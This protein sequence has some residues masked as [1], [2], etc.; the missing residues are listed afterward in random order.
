M[1]L[2]L[3]SKGVKACNFFCF[4]CHSLFRSETLAKLVL[5]LWIPKSIDHAIDF[6]KGLA[7]RNGS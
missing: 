5:I 2:S 1:L 4:I 7:I 6:L 3:T